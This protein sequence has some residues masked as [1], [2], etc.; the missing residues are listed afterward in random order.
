M[1]NDIDQILKEVHLIPSFENIHRQILPVLA[2]Q[3]E[4]RFFYLDSLELMRHYPGFADQIPIVT[5]KQKQ[6]LNAMFAYALGTGIVKPAESPGAYEKLTDVIWLQV[7][8]RLVEEK[9][10]GEIKSDEQFREDLWTLIFPYLTPHGIELL[11]KILD[12]NLVLENE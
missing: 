8:L 11:S 12:K 2:F 1:S 7:S 10:T 4:Y 6:Y 5:K 9:L 3:K